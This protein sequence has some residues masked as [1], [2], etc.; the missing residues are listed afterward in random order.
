M[1]TQSHLFK[2]GCRLNCSDPFAGTDRLFDKTSGSFPVLIL[3]ICFKRRITFH[4]KSFIL[5]ESDSYRFFSGHACVEDVA[6]E[7]DT[8]NDWL[9][10]HSVFFLEQVVVWQMT[11]GIR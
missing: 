3:N 5:T 8:D 1:M 6:D 7:G 10:L 9:L 2:L 4:R 11:L